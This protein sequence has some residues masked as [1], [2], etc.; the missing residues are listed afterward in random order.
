M[1]SCKFA[2]YFNLNQLIN[3]N[4]IWICNEVC[5]P[6][7]H[8][9]HA[10]HIMA[11]LTELLLVHSNFSLTLLLTNYFSLNH[12]KLYYVFMKYKFC[13]IPLL[14][15][16][17]CAVR[18]LSNGPAPFMLNVSLKSSTRDHIWS[19]KEGFHSSL[20][21]NIQSWQC[22]HFCIAS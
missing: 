11:Y 7:H 9:S 6:L 8:I 18:G 15:K 21:I 14:D 16:V 3:S 5:C 4:L 10:H 13:A 2:V 1:M 20:P 19:Q 12:T 22:G 17:W